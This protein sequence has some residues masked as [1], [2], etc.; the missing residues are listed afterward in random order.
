MSQ[1]LKILKHL[2]SGKSITQME[3]LN[4][5]GRMRLASRINDLREIYPIHTKMIY[6]SGKKFASYS[7]VTK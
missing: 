6:K 5:Y 3:A 1:T 4:L 7:L 2:K